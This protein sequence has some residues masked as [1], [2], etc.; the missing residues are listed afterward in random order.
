MS[1]FGPRK[2]LPGPSEAIVINGVK[3]CFNGLIYK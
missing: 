3:W 1:F 2:T